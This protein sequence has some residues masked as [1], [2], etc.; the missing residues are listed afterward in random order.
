MQGHEDNVT[1]IE[2]LDP[3]GSPQHMSFSCLV[4]TGYN[5]VLYRLDFVYVFYR[6]LICAVL[7]SILLGSVSGFI[8]SVTV[9][10]CVSR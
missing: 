2:G 5:A 1:A 3:F 9:C 6:A 4:A 10:V 7:A 8:C